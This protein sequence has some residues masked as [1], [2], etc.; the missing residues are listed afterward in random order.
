M[1]NLKKIVTLPTVSGFEYVGAQIVSEILKE[2]GAEVSIDKLSN[3]LALKNKGKDVKVL[4][5]AHFDTIGLMVTEIKDGGFL[6]FTTVG[7]VDPR[8]LPSLTVTS[9]GGTV[10]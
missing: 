6:K 5:D 3:V 9:N 1:D 8:I 10:H 4:L 7:G 2:S